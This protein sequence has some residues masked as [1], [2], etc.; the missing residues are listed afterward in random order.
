[1]AG[2]CIPVLELPSDSGPPRLGHRLLDVWQAFVAARA[3][4]NTFVAVAYDL[5]GRLHCA[6][7]RSGGGGSPGPAGL[8]R[9]AAGP[10]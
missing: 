10:S 8:H 7:E 2:V 4:P 3:R 5:K 1:M 9:G 6:G